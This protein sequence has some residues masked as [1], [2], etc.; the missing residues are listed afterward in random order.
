MECWISPLE[1]SFNLNSRNKHCIK[2]IPQKCQP[3]IS[4]GF[5]HLCFRIFLYWWHTV[6]K[7]TQNAAAI[8]NLGPWCDF[9][10]PTPFRGL[11]AIFTASHLYW[12]KLVLK[13]Q[14][15]HLCLLWQWHKKTLFKCDGGTGVGPRL[16]VK[17]LQQIKKLAFEISLMFFPLSSGVLHRHKVLFY[18]P[19][20]HKCGVY[21]VDVSLILHWSKPDRLLLDT[22]E[23]R[24]FLSRGVT[25]RPDTTVQKS[26]LIIFFLLLL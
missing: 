22:D 11:S 12:R 1:E 23:R 24:S 13:S 14:W 10:R 15:G 8:I 7:F 3:W 21:T 2:A 19:D 17:L 16:W 6:P 4:V 20:T 5:I 26:W 18:P 25:V 9:T